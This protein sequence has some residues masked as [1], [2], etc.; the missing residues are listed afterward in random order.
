MNDAI[1]LDLQVLYPNNVTLN[2]VVGLYTLIM[3]LKS[4]H[5]I[6][7]RTPFSQR[8][9]QEFQKSVPLHTLAFL[10]LATLLC[11]TK[12]INTS[13]VRKMAAQC[14]PESSSISDTMLVEME[15]LLK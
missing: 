14:V 2:A 13:A 1:F 10:I 12:D 6:E 3:I 8:E 9:A 11:S 15:L 5:Y 7:H 4:T